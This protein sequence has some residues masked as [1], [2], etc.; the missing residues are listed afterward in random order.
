MRWVLSVA[1]LT[2]SVLASAAQVTVAPADGVTPAWSV[3]QSEIDG[4]SAAGGGTLVLPAGDYL[5]AQLKLKSGVTIH[6]RENAVLLASTNHLDYGLGSGTRGRLAV[7]CADGA[8]D[9]G[10]IGEGIVDGRGGA[11]G[12]QEEGADRW[13][14]VHFRNCRSARLVGVTLENSN[15]WSVYFDHCD[16]VQAKDVKIRSQV[17]YNN[18]GFDIESKNVVIE[19]CEIDTDDD[20][21]CF[22][23]ADPDY[24]VENCEVKDCTV[25]SHCNF[26]KFGTASHGIFRNIDVHD[27]TLVAHGGGVRDWTKNGQDVP[28]RHW[29]ISGIALEVVDGGGL[30]R[31]KVRNIDVR[32]G[33]ICPIFIRL[34]ERTLHPGLREPFLRDVLVENV[35]YSAY[36]HSLQPV[37]VSGVPGRRIRNVTIR[38]VAVNFKAR[39]RAGDEAIIVPEREKAYPEIHEFVPRFPCW[40]TFVRHAENVRFENFLARTVGGDDPRPMARTD[41]DTDNVVFANDDW[42]NPEVNARNRLPARTYTVPLADEQAALTDGLEF[43][44]PYRLSLDGLWKISWSGDSA[45]RVRG[46]EAPSFDD[47]EWATVDVPSCVELRG[48]GT[49]GYVNTRYPHANRPPFILDVETLKGDYN[50]VSAYRRKFTVPEAWRGRRIVLRFDGVYSAYNVW[51]NGRKVGYAEDSKLPSEFDITDHAWVGENVLAVEVYR[52]CDGSYLEDQDMFRFSGIFRDV[53]IWSMPKDGIWDFTVRTTPDG[54]YER[55]KVEV[56][57]AEG[58]SVSLYDADKKKVCDLDSTPVPNLYT[59]TTLAARAWSAED[60]YLYTLVVKKGSDIRARRIGFKEQKVVGNRL[61]VNGRPIKFKGV[62]RHDVSPENGRAVSLAEMKRDAELMKRYNFNTVRTSHYPN[63]RLWYDLCD[64]YGLYVCAEANVEGF[65]TGIYR[66]DGLGDDP[67]WESSIV[68]RNL[69]HVAFYRNHPSV[70]FW[71][72][73][74][75]TSHGCNFKKAIAEVRSLD[76]SRPIHWEAGN[77]DADVDSIMYPDID[78]LEQR[79]RLGEGLVARMGEPWDS[80]RCT[81]GV[82]RQSRGKV[83]FLCEYAHAMGNALG[84]F[85]EYWDVFYRYDS[86]CGGCI[87]DWIDQVVWK[88]TDPDVRGEMRLMAYGGDFD[89][90]PNDGPFCC[91]GVIGP[92]RQVTPKLIEAGHVLR[93]LVV[94][95]KGDGF[96]LENRHEFVS[97]ARFDGRWE[98]LKD[99]EKV[100]SGTFAVPDVAPRMRA[101]LALPDVEPARRGLT[102]EQLL[103]ISFVTRGGAPWAPAGWCVSRNQIRLRDAAPAARAKAVCPEILPD[104]KLITVRAGGTSAVFDRRTGTLCRLAMDGREILSQEP[105]VSPSGPHLTWLRAFTDNDHRVRKAVLAAGLTQA[106]RRALPIELTESGVRTRVDVTTMKSAGFRHEMTW[107]FD[108]G[109]AVMVA[110]RVEPFGSFPDRIPRLGLSWRLADALEHVRYYGRGPWENYVDRLTGSFLGVYESTVSDLYVGYVRP[111][112]NGYRCDVR[113]FELT[114][115]DGRGV[116]VSGSEPLFVQALRYGWEDLELARHRNGEFRRASLPPPRHEI[117]LNTDVRQLGLGGAACGPDALARFAFDPRGKL[118]WAIRLEPASAESKGAR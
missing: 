106:N 116:R 27:C 18:D 35:N 56:E 81:Q 75:E 53:S 72:L 85:A 38:N 6:L 83:S 29:G 111:Q 58:A 10:V 89:E 77:R 12:L 110:S 91:N 98:L 17:N 21:I 30:E 22:K 32:G 44:S 42:Q 28:D 51:V 62:N 97:A 15:Y 14:L 4:L 19:S 13:R 117:R 101:E 55:W 109:G 40:G 92:D 8:E 31:V 9:I 103:N 70:T 108:E 7:V 74:N 61:L 114:D 78:W 2:A 107:T 26:I 24:V 5:V 63:H 41:C 23:N 95:R 1:V 105:S 3:L 11:Q 54:G 25:S 118:S 67:R 52:W 36:A 94:R 20:A 68:E 46:F 43:E 79:G 34:G 88:A 96:E 100:A 104:E 86:L 65:G 50:P 39:G 45:A 59:S 66:E 57:G 80:N 60:P 76:P 16:G 90:E 69:R 93:N 87:W 99:G 102:G 33:V 113:W 115:G 48:F 112:D 37:F 82:R 73:G 49:P 71:S 47:S 64:R 84:N